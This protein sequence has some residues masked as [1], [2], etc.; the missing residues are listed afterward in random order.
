[1]HKNELIS[2]LA[3]PTTLYVHCAHG[4]AAELFFLASGGGR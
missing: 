1:M 4:Q 3:K 2:N